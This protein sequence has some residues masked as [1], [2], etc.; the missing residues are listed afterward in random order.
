[1]C[2]VYYPDTEKK[3]QTERKEKSAANE[4][5]FSIQEKQAALIALRKAQ[6]IKLVT[7]AAKL[8]CFIRGQ[9]EQGISPSATDLENITNATDDYH[10]YGLHGSANMIDDAMVEWSG[11]LLD[12]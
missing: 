6:E 3:E 8:T 5:P 10:A 9:H 12:A 2:N 11:L 1:M 7:S 4:C